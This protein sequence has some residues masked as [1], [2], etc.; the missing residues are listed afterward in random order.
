MVRLGLSPVES[1]TNFV[2]I[3]THENA[4]QVTEELMKRGVIVR[5]A[6]N[7]G[8][9]TSIRV[10]VGTREQNRRFIEIMEELFPP[11]SSL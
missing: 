5:S 11:P 4:D 1:S 6:K 7:Y 3:D 2:L 8:T 9:P 10:T